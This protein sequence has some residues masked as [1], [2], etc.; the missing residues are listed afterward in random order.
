MLTPPQNPCMMLGKSFEPNFLQ[1]VTVLLLTGHH[2]DAQGVWFTEVLR[3]IEVNG[4][5][6]WTKEAS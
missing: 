1:V 5:Q 6:L 3:A 2:C 4:S